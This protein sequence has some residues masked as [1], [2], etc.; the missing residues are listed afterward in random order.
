M[1]DELKKIS[2]K[3]SKSTVAKERPA[4]AKPRKITAKSNEAVP[5]VG[6]ESRH[7]KTIE[8][9]RNETHAQ[10]KKAN[11]E[12]YT[13]DEEE[14]ES[15]DESVNIRDSTA[16]QK[17][18]KSKKETRDRVPV[19]SNKIVKR[20][21]AGGRE[22]KP[23]AI[24]KKTDVEE[25][26]EANDGTVKTREAH[27]TQNVARQKT[28]KPVKY[29]AKSNK[30]V[31]PLS[32]GGREK[33]P[34]VVEPNAND[35]AIGVKNTRKRGRS[36]QLPDQPGKKVSTR[37]FTLTKNENG[38]GFDVVE[39]HGKWLVSSVTPKSPAW[40][41]ILANDC[42]IHIGNAHGGDIDID[43]ST[44]MEELI[45]VLDMDDCFSF[46]VERYM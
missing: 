2:D 46:R 6:T 22:R 29:P 10:N 7:K 3:Y 42:I 18:T 31:P 37:N 43:S 21:G 25:A 27:A 38:F 39:S 30:A 16:T 14:T 23:A 17:V 36:T 26:I 15:D 11:A 45:S 24:R 8:Q 40:K 9:K 28:E 44:T 35:K 12:E 13:S 19:K 5:P 1:D 32:A 34:T 20:L 33:K 41:K 4:E